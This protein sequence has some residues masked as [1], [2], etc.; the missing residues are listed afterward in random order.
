[1]IE[2][3]G[4]DWDLGFRGFSVVVGLVFDGRD[5]P[6]LTVESTVAVPVDPL[7]GGQ[8]DLG[9]CPPGTAGLDQLGL[10]QAMPRS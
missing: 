1:L 10:E 8:L 7:R 2:T 4:R 9:E 6:D 3:L 5:V